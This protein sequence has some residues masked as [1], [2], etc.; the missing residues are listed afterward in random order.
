M[1][2]AALIRR[3][4]PAA[5]AAGRARMQAAAAVLGL[6]LAL[7]LA[8]L[9]R[10]ALPAW[11][12]RPPK[13]W[14][15]DLAGPVNRFLAWLSQEAAIGPVTVKGL[16][17]GIASGFA[18]PLDLLQGLLVKGIDLPLPGGT[19]RLAALPWWALAAAA[20]IFGH[21]VAGRRAAGL[22]LATCGYFLVLGLWEAAMQT[23]ASVAV[24]VVVGAI[25]GI[26]LGAAA[27]RW[28][29]LDAGLNL[30]YDVMQTLPVFSYL[31]PILLFFGFGPVAALIAT[32]IYAMP[33]MARNTTLAL[34]RLPASVMELASMAGCSP[35]QR[36][37]LV[38]LPA[39]RQGLLTGFNQLVMLSLSAVI[40]ASVIGAGGLGNVVLQGLKSMQLGRAFEAGL[41]ITLMA[42][43]LDRL[44]HA[45]AL[46][47]PA[48]G[49]QRAGLRRHPALYG[50]LAILVAGL[51]AAQTVPAL[52][53]F[54]EALTGS[55]GR[56]LDNFFAWANV[57]LEAPI[58]AVRD[59]VVR[60]L[61]RPAKEAL[62]A[63]PWLAMA[64]LVAVLAYA[65][66]GAAL[67]L[68]CTAMLGFIALTGYWDLAMTSLYLVG[69]STLIAT[70]IGFPIGVLAAQG[71][72]LGRITALVI[73]TLQTLPT[74]V[75]LI[76]VV[77]LFGL[78]DFPAMVA[79]VLF[80]LPPAIRYPMDGI[81]RVPKSLVEAADMAGCTRLQRLALV[82][83]PQ[84]LP[85]IMLGLSQTILMA[86]GMLVITALV[87]TR[88]L[89]QETLVAVSK[90]RVG[91]G[92]IAGL[93][94]S[95][96]SIMAD[97]LITHGSARLRR[98]LGQG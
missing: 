22:V 46:R 5:S 6:I 92:L 85:E 65:A 21:W 91:E 52:R 41:G 75:Y 50:A 40:I 12:V 43:V 76:P 55:S 30:V 2:M 56:T 88:G 57:A 70:L 59:G 58:G 15:F 17:R 49:N 96:L 7:V 18:L 77:M 20:A 45:V 35:R 60:H 29:R 94:I 48:H 68:A 32:V 11:V 3:P 26:A 53:D 73:D 69:I 38:L 63:L 81:A 78:G 31:V 90:A 87:G 54:P 13:G 9:W 16:T 72:R 24:A 86:F 64:G 66:S 23:L 25:L 44:S 79:I 84:A 61:F 42:I 14:L 95:F 4:P 10:D 97:R 27:H 19:L 28:P 83:I 93:G 62:L 71:P 51:A 74:F 80:A 33:P 67:A 34:R 36:L 47:R 37:F 98:R 1:M 82:Q 89:E 8:A 39:A